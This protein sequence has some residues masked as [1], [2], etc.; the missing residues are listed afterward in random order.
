MPGTEF[1][2]GVPRSP[3][4]KRSMLHDV[5]LWEVVTRLSV[6]T[7]VGAAVLVPQELS[8]RHLQIVSVVVPPDFDRDVRVQLFQTFQRPFRGGVPVHQFRNVL[9][10]TDHLAT[11]Y[12]TSQGGKRKREKLDEGTGGQKNRIE[13]NTSGQNRKMRIY[14]RLENIFYQSHQKHHD[15]PN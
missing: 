4:S 6:A 5:S 10:Q 14:V 2:N 12:R 8:D 9:K 3:F 7:V 1:H 11:E 13:Q 15:K